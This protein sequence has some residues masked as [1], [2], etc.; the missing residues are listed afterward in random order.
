M[1]RDQ[2]QG[3]E[4][5]SAARASEPSHNREWTLSWTALIRI[6]TRHSE[7][8]KR[9]ISN[10]SRIMPPLLEIKARDLPCCARG[11]LNIDANFVCPPG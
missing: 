11:K 10:I 1:S 5:A 3:S 8:L 7:F 6:S 4:G 2:G 9:L